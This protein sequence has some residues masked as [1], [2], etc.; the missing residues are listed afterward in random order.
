MSLSPILSSVSYIFAYYW[1]AG[2]T[3]QGRKQFKIKMSNT[4]HCSECITT[5]FNSVIHYLSLTAAAENKTDKIVW[6]S[7]YSR[8]IHIT[9][10]CS[11]QPVYKI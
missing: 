9:E 4:P 5:H 3:P 6:N 11:C 8:N 7:K 2:K 10:Q 1:G